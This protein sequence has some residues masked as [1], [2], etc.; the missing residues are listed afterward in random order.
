MDEAQFERVIDRLTHQLLEH[1][2]FSNTDLVGL[3]P[4]GYWFA[5]IIQQ[6]LQ[7]ILG[8]PIFCGGWM[9]PFIEMIFAGEKTPYHRH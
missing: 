7:A 9:S 3:Q 2:D 5:Q 8:K 4:R 1:H 6:R